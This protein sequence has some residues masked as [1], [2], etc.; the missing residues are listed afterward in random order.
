MNEAIEPPPWIKNKMMGEYVKGDTSNAKP[1]R[2]NKQR[3]TTHDPPKEVG[4]QKRG[5]YA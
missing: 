1:H 3:D 4:V 5:I 2:L